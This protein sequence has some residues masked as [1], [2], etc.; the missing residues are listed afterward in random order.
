[1][2]PQLWLELSPSHIRHA[3]LAAVRQFPQGMHGVALLLHCLAFSCPTL[4]IGC[5]LS[6]CGLCHGWVGWGTIFFP[7]LPFPRGVS[8][9][10]CFSQP[11]VLKA[12]TLEP[13]SVGRTPGGWWFLHRLRPSVDGP[14]WTQWGSMPVLV[15]DLAP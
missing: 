9:G 10:R 7:G 6:S 14:S 1:M 5:H 2:T 3:Q 12:Y 15:R 13:H 8:E 4:E 11:A